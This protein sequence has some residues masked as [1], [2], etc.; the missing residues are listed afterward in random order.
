[1]SDDERPAPEVSAATRTLAL[2]NQQADAVR[3]DLAN[4]RRDLASARQE[5]SGLRTAQLVEANDEL[6]LAAVHADLVARTA[7]SSLDELTRSTQ[8]D[9]LT[10]APNRALLLDRLQ[11]AISL[12][13]RRGN[14]VG[15]IF[16]DLDQFKAINDTLGHAAGDEVLQLTVRRLESVV[17]ESDSVSRHGGDEFVILLA[18]IS[19]PA[20]AA[21]IADKILEAL[22]AP[23]QIGSH[24]LHPSASLGISVYPDDA[25]DPVSLIDRADAAMYVAKKCGAGRYAFSGADAAADRND[26]PAGDDAR[27]QDSPPVPPAESPAVAPARRPDTALAEHEARLRELLEANQQLVGAAQAAQQLQAAAEQAHHRQINFVAMAAHALRN[28]LSAIRMATATLLH[29]RVDE[30]LRVA[31]HLVIQR[32]T[33]LMARLI[34][35]LLDGSRVGVGEFRL[36]CSDLPLDGIVAAAVDACRHAIDA[37]H[38]ALRVALPEEAPIVNGDPQRLIQVFGNLLNNASRRAPQGGEL[39]LTVQAIDGV[40]RVAV[41]HDGVGISAEA[42]PHVFDL[43]SV[44]TDVPI[45]ESGLGIGMAV[46]HALVKAHGG[47]V[48]AHSG[49]RDRGSEF[50]VRLPRV[51]TAAQALEQGATR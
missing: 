9:D 45:D 11:T 27:A 29:P 46:V 18:D 20:D 7:F 51:G 15:V 41:T 50:V 26:A 36:Q 28:P 19:K 32:Q 13:Q 40:A 47:S 43:F 21:T 30:G 31:Q 22:G 12:A 33:A 17:R 23:A 14:R 35:D 37:K 5:L 8:Y 2:L 10:G 24:T 16:V 4:L 34:D 48:D 25:A 49:G 44:D 42:L 3:A 38:Q 39:A 1:V 6:V